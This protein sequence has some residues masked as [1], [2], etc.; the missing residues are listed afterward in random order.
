VP[1]GAF[2]PVLSHLAVETPDEVIEI[3]AGRAGAEARRRRRELLNRLTSAQRQV[4]RLIAEGNAPDEVA[5][6]LFVT[7][8]TVASHLTPIYDEFRNVWELPEETRLS[9]HDLWR[10]FHEHFGAV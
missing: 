4:L 2:F 7:R 10:E 1:W 8:S 9:Y 3:V 6:R 5:R